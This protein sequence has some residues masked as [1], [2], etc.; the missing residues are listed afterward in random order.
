MSKF[1][2]ILIFCFFGLFV[3]A[4]KSITGTVTDAVSQEPLLGATIVVENTTNG[5][6]TD[7]DGKFT[8]NNVPDTAAIVVSYVGYKST[9]I[10]IGLAT[11][12]PIALEP[13]VESLEDIV[14]IGYGRESRRNITGAISKVDS[15]SIERLEPQNA[16]QALQGTASGINVTQQGGSPGSESNIRIRGIATNLDASPLIILDGFEYRGGL[17][18]INPQDIESI[19][20]LKDAQAAIYGSTGSNGVILITTKSGK[21][22]Q[23]T[24]F[25]Y[26]TY[27]GVQQTSRKIPLLNA[28]EYALLLNE[29]YTNAGQVSP[30]DN[31]SG[32]GKGTDWQNEVFDTAP[33]M[34]HNLS[35]RGGSENISYSISGSLLD[36][37]GIVGSEK[38]EFS[39]KTASLSLDASITE[40]FSINTKLFYAASKNKSLN[41]FGLGSVLFNALN[42][43]PT[44][45]PEVDNLTNEIDLGNEVVNPLTQIRNTFN[46]SKTNRLSGTFQSKLEYAKNLDLQGRIGFNTALTQNRDFFPVFDYGTG[47]VFNR[48]EDN[49]VSLGKINDNDYTFDLFNTYQNNFNDR[50]NLTLMLGMT[51]FQTKGEGLFG[52]ATGVPSNLY[53]FADLSLATG[54]G[55]NRNANSYAYDVRRLS[56]FGRVQYSLDNR[57]LFSAMLRRD[58]STRFGPNNRVGY[59]PSVTAGWIVSDE[60]FFPENNFIDFIKIRASY[61]IIGNDRIGDF[62]YLSLLT[63]EATY[64]SGV[65]GS[66]INGVAIGPLSNPNIKWE[67]AKKLDVGVDFRLFKNKLNFV[68][69]YYLND[70][71]DLLVSNIPI[72]GIFGTYAPGGSGP[73]INAGSVRNQG[74]EIEFSYND[75]LSENLKINAGFNLSTIQNTVTEINGTDFIEGGQFGVGQPAPSRM[76][77]G[78]PIGYFYGYQ[79]NGIFQNIAEVN[80][81]PSQ[82]LLGAEAQ[83]GDIRYVDANG[84]GVIDS[85]DRVNIGDPIPDFTFGINLGFSYK[86][87]DFNTYAFASVGND[88][89]RNYE[90]AQDNVNKLNYR[91]DRWTGEGT[92]NSVPRVTTA[93]S[94]NNI[95]S[96]FFV[97][98]GSFLRIQ[99]VSLG[100]NF[101]ENI[102][103]KIKLKKLRVYAKVD[104]LYTFT[105]YSGFDPTASTGA[106]IGAGIDFGFYPIPRIYSFGVNAQF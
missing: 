24:E 71:K 103:S 47:K 102:I 9:T 75:N 63:G 91:L 52:S 8:L 101:Q 72:S 99:T 16:A 104:N 10:P 4:Q 92:S 85:N 76:E 90:R 41:D 23:E 1:Y 42:M 105:E 58:A 3:S 43:A 100:Y 79:T 18:S 65:D 7:F 50:H 39:R 2:L 96:D 51:V 68:F 6:T 35:I 87:F 86:N 93:P 84:D 44:I 60:N 27:V 70:T 40:I 78:K 15:E 57:Y 95:F 20:V 66:L 106:P 55:D 69:D 19:T 33:I 59:F 98:D 80:A 11:N 89:V 31:F 97:E 73:T 17:N 82:I 22:N 62:R 12:Y 5:T 61:G 88:I 14:V 46:D 29:S 64:P 54:S 94:A 56:Y 83:P 34:N 21:R 81:H 48:L 13:D 30:I 26:Q 25:N 53:T 36:Q 28:T 45:G 67:E 38:S 74:I 32:L 37:E 77:V 49:L